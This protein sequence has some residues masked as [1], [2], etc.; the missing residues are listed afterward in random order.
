MDVLIWEGG[1]Y[2]F[3]VFNVTRL[4]IDPTILGTDGEHVDHYTTEAAWKS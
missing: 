3:L 2:K 1:K 4:G